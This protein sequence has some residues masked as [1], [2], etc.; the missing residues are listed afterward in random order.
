MKLVGKI[1]LNKCVIEKINWLNPLSYSLNIPSSDIL[2][3]S[4]PFTK[5]NSDSKSRGSSWWTNAVAL[6]A[7]DGPNQTPGNACKK[8]K[9]IGQQNAQ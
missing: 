7:A 9:K 8:G 6:G 4:I 1:N 3:D 2:D 5:S